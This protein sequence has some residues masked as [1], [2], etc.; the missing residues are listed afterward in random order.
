MKGWSPF[1]KPDEKIDESGDVVKG[2]IDVKKAQHIKEFMKNYPRWVKEEKEHEER[3]HMK[4]LLD[5]LYEYKNYKPPKEG[6]N[7]KSIIT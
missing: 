2:Q 4:D 5:N 1:T 6:S 7:R 3:H